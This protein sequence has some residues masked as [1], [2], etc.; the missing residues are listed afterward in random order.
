MNKEIPEHIY[1]KNDIDKAFIMGIDA[2]L[3][4]FE[5]TIGMSHNNQRSIINKIKNML[6]NDKASFV[7]NDQ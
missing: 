3:S 2:A 4:L 6:K 1:Y 5:E 7:I